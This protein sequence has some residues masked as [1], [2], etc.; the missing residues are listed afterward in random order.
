MAR[1][2]TRST[3]VSAPQGRPLHLDRATGR[4]YTGSE[5]GAKPAAAV[6]FLSQRRAGGTWRRRR[7]R[8][9]RRAGRSGRAAAVP[10][11]VP[12]RESSS[13][14][15]SGRAASSGC[16]RRV[17]ATASGRVDG[18]FGGMARARKTE[19]AAGSSTKSKGFNLLEDEEQHGDDGQEDL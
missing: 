3:R 4:S 11:A 13:S 8:P 18:G 10:A 6:E 12:R 1:K 17:A 5:P 7:R 16:A 2:V 9:R 15:A 14:P 19:K